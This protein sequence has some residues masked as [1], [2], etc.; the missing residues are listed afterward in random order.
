M[1]VYEN[2]QPLPEKLYS[3]I[4]DRACRCSEINDEGTQ[5]ALVKVQ[6][7]MHVLFLMTLQ[8]LQTTSVSG[9]HGA[10]L[11]MGVHCLYNMFAGSKQKSQVFAA[12]KTAI[13]DIINS[14]FHLVKTTKVFERYFVKACH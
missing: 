7:F 4:T 9:A 12:A 10:A 1:L 11:L 13:T 14:I 5:V 8:F 6:A 3:R 2:N